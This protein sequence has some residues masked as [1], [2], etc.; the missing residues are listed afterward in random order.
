M[1]PNNAPQYFKKRS[2]LWNAV[3]KSE[4]RKNSQTARHINVALP[5][6]ISRD[7]QIDLVRKF[8]L[9]CFISRGMCADFA[10]H[11]KDDGNP[12]VHILLTTRKVDESGF[13]QKERSWNDKTLLLEW[14]KSWADWCNHKNKFIP[15]FIHTP[16]KYAI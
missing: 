13:T 15:T 8:C 5:I 2:V 16:R 11:D 6:E 10:I 9:Q 12:H 1:L 7:E 4:T 3:E 14:R